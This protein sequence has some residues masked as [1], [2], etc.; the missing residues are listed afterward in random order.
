MIVPDMYL[1]VALWIYRD[2]FFLYIA[3]VS[4]CD[5]DLQHDFGYIPPAATSATNKHVGDE[6][7]CS[8]SQGVEDEASRMSA[9]ILA[10]QCRRRL[11][12]RRSNIRF[13]YRPATSGKTTPLKNLEAG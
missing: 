7:A 12:R 11:T 6:T 3:G 1:T 5:H 10:T 8:C 9:F 4:P 13:P 2:H